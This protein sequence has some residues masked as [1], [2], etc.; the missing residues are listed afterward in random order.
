MEKLL[1]SVWFVFTAIL[2][3]WGCGDGDEPK[4]DQELKEVVASVDRIRQASQKTL[5]QRD[6][7]G[8]TTLMLAVSSFQENVDAVQALI[9]RGVDVNAKTADGST[10]LAFAFLYNREQVAK[11]LFAGGATPQWENEANMSLL[12]AAALGGDG[13]VFDLVDEPFIRS[14]AHQKNSEGNS[15]LHQ[16]IQVFSGASYHRSF[17]KRAVESK[18]F[19][20]SLQNTEGKTACE[21]A[22]ASWGEEDTQ[23]ATQLIDDLCTYPK[24]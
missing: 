2:P 6:S 9:Q 4:S 19:D 13:F 14:H 1:T 21:L 17:I 24:S 22:I 15:P 12:H 7:Q 8:Y 5:E 20:L 23:V 11:I 18:L 3:I 10:A 16:A